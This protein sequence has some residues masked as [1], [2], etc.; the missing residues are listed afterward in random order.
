MADLACRKSKVPYWRRPWFYGLLLFIM[1]AIMVQSGGELLHAQEAGQPA[2]GQ[3]QAEEA[4][5]ASRQ[6]TLDDDIDVF[7]EAEF[8]DPLYAVVLEGWREAG[9]EDTT[10]VS[11]TIDPTRYVRKYASEVGSPARVQ[12][13]YDYEGRSG[14]ALLWLDE[15]TIIEWEVDIPA[16]GFYNISFEYLPL[17][18]K[19][20]SIQRDLKIDDAYPFNEARRLIFPRTWRD[21]HRP[22]R[23]NQGNDVRP[24][25]EEVR[26]WQERYF[27]DP[28]GMYREPFRFY[29]TKG[30]HRLTMNA[31]REPMALGAIKIT[32]PKRLPTY[33]EMKKLYEEKGYKVA[34]GEPIRVQTEFPDL[35]SDPTIR[36]EYSYDPSAIP[37]A[38]SNMILNV[39]GGSRWRK[40][41]QWAEWKFSVPEDGLYKIGMKVLQQHG[42]RLPVARK[43]EID[44]EV[45]FRE[46]EEF[47]FPYDRDPQIV[48][49]GDP[50]GEPYY[51]YL[52]KGE[53]VLRM[54]AVVGPVA[55]TIRMANSAS[56]EFAKLSRAIVMI[57]GPNPDPN[58]DWEIH[59]K[60]P[61]LLPRMQA[62]E[63]AFGQEGKWLREFSPK[64]RLADS[65]DLSQAIM[66][67]MIRRP[68]TITNRLREFSDQE[69]R[70]S[71]WVLDLQY[72]ALE[73]DY[74]VVAP[75]DYTFPNV[76]P[77]MWERFVAGLRSFL[78][79]FTKDYTL[80]GDVY[81]VRDGVDETG[82]KV[83]TLWVGW[84]REWTAIIKEMIDEDF[85][86]E[87][88]IKVNVN[89]IPAGALG[90]G[91][92][93]LLLSLAA[94]Q[95]PDV[96][97]GTPAGTPVEF[98]IRGG[99]YNLNQFPDYNEVITRF[100]PGALIPFKYRGGDYA[101]P[102]TQ[103][104]SMMFYRKDILQQFRI[105]PPETWDDVI[106]ILP[107]LQQ[108]GMNFYY[109]GGL[110]P[111]L[112][113]HG[114][115]YYYAD[116]WYSALD[117]P[118]ALA[119]FKAWTELYA[120]YKIPVSANFYNRMRTGEMPI[121]IA[122]YQ[123]YVLLST[124]APELTGWWEMVPMP[125]V[126]RAD[127][128]IDRTAAGGS[129]TSVIY[130]ASR[131]KEEAW[132]LMKW[133]TSTDIQARFGE[134]VEAVLG[135]EARW[136]TANVE[137]LM[138]MPWPKKDILA[139]REQWQ[140]FKE[141]PVVL[142][143]YFTSRHIQN[144]WN[145]VVLQGMNPREA[146]E[147]AVKDIDRELAKKQE[148]F[149]TVIPTRREYIE[150]YGELRPGFSVY[151]ETYG[152]E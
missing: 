19:R 126:R 87:T 102:E 139:I 91:Q 70:L 90:T 86:P 41:Q 124:A 30:K 2:T 142:G 17:D 71:Q 103:S 44:G 97:F 150:Q 49:L 140:W 118:E 141:Q 40:G 65:L 10:G 100:R 88:G 104:F 27:E 68:D 74:F 20:A 47:L 60:I 89:V 83:L 18:G 119:A 48:T 5:P 58:F 6:R 76:K 116:G 146:L 151:R 53:H 148:E 11:I 123:T 38:G 107:T 136:N 29:F 64:T 69:L 22:R 12:A 105:S 23:D 93:V 34:Q 43:I 128:V 121:G 67:S 135:V 84:G 51:I 24:R 63:Q 143:G 110:T 137:A 145:R 72:G 62:L 26:V 28:Q 14:S 73:I 85:T 37:P 114:G 79:S 7:D 59:K 94:G 120:N 36:S 4:A 78:L 132:E 152:L 75:P 111:F 112:Y 42:E 77:S 122:D 81:N 1:A 15:E 16:S 98:A 31:I 101:L 35:K 80:V 144:A 99:V 39:F 21:A 138:N 149:G 113:Q 108:Y 54:T 117:S 56:L 52:T 46:L 25:Q 147:I 82:E 134:E 92:S 109:A 55:R 133:W 61:E 130:T 66:G 33:A 45:P 96:S 9:Y 125:G 3:N 50:N 106:K 32:S 57:T 13:V 8:L 127:G 95:A 131:Y 129:T 115:E